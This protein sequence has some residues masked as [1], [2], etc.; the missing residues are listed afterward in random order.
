MLSVQMPNCLKVMDMITERIKQIAEADM[1]DS[2]LAQVWGCFLLVI[3]LLISPV[4][5]ISA[6]NAISAIQV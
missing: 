2:L 1:Y 6:K 3:V 4:L 5:V